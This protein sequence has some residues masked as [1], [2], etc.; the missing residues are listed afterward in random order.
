M[1]RPEMET[2]S[3]YLHDA[4]EPIVAN[5]YRG[6]GGQPGR[7]TSKDRMI[8]L[9]V[10]AISQGKRLHALSKSMHQR[11]RQ[12][13]AILIQCGG[14]AHHEEFHQE[15]ILSLGGNVREWS[16]VMANLGQ[17][18]MV[19]ASE[20][21]DGHFFYVVPDPLLEHL[22]DPLKDDLVLPSFDHEDVKIIEERSFM[23]PLTYS[24]TTLATYI[25]QHP[26]RLTQRQEIYKV[27][28]EEMDQFFSQIWEPDSELFAFHI[29]F[30]MI[31]GMVELRGDHLSLNHAVLEEWLRLDPQDQRDLVMS[32]LD[33]KFAL[34]EWVLWAIFDVGGAWLPERP[35]QALYRRWMRA[36]DWRDRFHKD[37]WASLRTAERESYAFTPLVQCGML[38][39]GQ[40]GQEKFY[41]LTPRAQQMLEP[42]NDESFSQFYLTPSFE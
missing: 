38:E 8:Q 13:L 23:P 12:A 25:D 18:G 41:R 36:E 1:T 32:A 16:K 22:L 10:R 21:R 17:Q 28:K 20:A 24:I 5:L 15:L 7:I 3:A 31:Q 19:A 40:W 2:L 26:P 39:M 30:L 35:L 34:A 27:H 29:E 37:Q 4:P 11:D 33:K 9:A 42:P 14:L 6:M